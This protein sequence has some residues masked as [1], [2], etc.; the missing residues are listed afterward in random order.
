MIMNELE[1][2]PLV[3]FYPCV[4]CDFKYFL[5]NSFI[6]KSKN[7]LPQ[8]RVTWHRNLQLLVSNYELQ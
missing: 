6:L 3:L 2:L 5:S 4:L 8:P 1:D 7:F